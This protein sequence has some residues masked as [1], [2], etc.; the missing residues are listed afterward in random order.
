MSVN[1][2]EGLAGRHVGAQTL[3]NLEGTAQDALDDA[4]GLHRP[5]DVAGQDLRRAHRRVCDGLAEPRGLSAS[6]VLQRTV[7]VAP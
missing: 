6:A 5:V 1:G 3:I 2:A 4:G 7:V